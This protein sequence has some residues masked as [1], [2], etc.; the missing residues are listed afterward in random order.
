MHKTK[1]KVVFCFCFK[2]SNAF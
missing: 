1:L 2:I